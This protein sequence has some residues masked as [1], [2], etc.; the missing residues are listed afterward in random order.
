MNTLMLKG[1]IT[2]L[3]AVIVVILILWALGIVSVSGCNGKTVAATSAVVQIPIPAVQVDSAAFYKA[4]LDKIV[5]LIELQEA[6]NALKN[7]KTGMGIRHSGHVSVDVVLKDQRT[8]EQ[9]TVTP[10]VLQPV[11][12][13]D[14]SDNLK[15]AGVPNMSTKVFTGTNKEIPDI[16][17]CAWLGRDETK[18]LPQLAIQDGENFSNQKDNGYQSFN[19]SFPRGGEFDQPTGISGRLKDGRNFVIAELVDRYLQDCD[20]KIVES[21][22][23]YDAWLFRE[24]FKTDDGKY[25]INK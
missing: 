19:W 5:R 10:I 15:N 25:Y 13:Q 7:K 23:N 16:Q 11:V 2:G 3:S 22:C 14:L 12:L 8:K 21:R 6:Q 17:L 1:I 4:E 9:S 20:V 18:W 24:M